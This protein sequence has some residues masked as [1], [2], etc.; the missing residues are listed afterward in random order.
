VG[1]LV[2][3]H[4]S[5]D[6]VPAGTYSKLKPRNHGPFKIL[7]RINDNIYVIDLPK[8]YNMSKSFNI[9]DI[10]KYYP[11]EIAKDQFGAIDPIKGVHDA[12]E[13]PIIITSSYHSNII[14]DGVDHTRFGYN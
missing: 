5:K 12:V 4:I 2:M 11:E 9:F 1:E 14:F 3:V 6:R 7:R 8:E 13:D 10:R